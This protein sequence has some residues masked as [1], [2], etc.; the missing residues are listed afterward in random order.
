MELDTT[1][2]IWKGLTSFVQKK[3]T[4]AGG[5]RHLSFKEEDEC[6]SMCWAPTSLIRPWPVRQLRP[7]PLWLS[8]WSQGWRE[9]HRPTS[10]ECYIP[11]NYTVYMVPVSVVYVLP[12][13]DFPEK[14]DLI[15]YIYENI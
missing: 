7:R 3:R 13:V 1:N 11:T 9:G 12:A 10:C 4:R 2:L 15:K 6:V 5:A 8:S 14:E